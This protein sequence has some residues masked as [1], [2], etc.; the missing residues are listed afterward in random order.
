ILA[1]INTTFTGEATSRWITAMK[2]DAFDE[3]EEAV[4]PAGEGSKLNLSMAAVIDRLFD[5][6]KRYSFEFNRTQESREFEISCERPASMR[7][8]AE[9]HD[10]GKPIK[11]CLGHLASR[12][13]AL[14]I[15]GEESRILAYITP[16]E[17]LV[18]F[19]PGLSDFP[20][21]LEMRTMKDPAKT[22]RDQVWAIK[23][24]ILSVDSLPVLARRLFTQLVKVSKGEA[25]NTELF[26][27]SP[28][29]E[30]LALAQ[31]AVAPVDRTFEVEGK[32]L[33]GQKKPLAE[34]T[35]IVTPEPPPMENEITADA[36]DEPANKAD[37]EVPVQTAPA[38]AER[39]PL[40]AL[41]SPA[42]MPSLAASS[43]YPQVA[44]AIANG[45][46]KALNSPPNPL[47]EPP[48]AVPQQ[49][50]PVQPPPIP[51]SLPI[52]A[53]APTLVAE[54]SQLSEDEAIAALIFP[55]PP[56]PAG[57]PPPEPAPPPVPTPVPVPVAVSLPP[58][59][60]A[61]A[62][63]PPE[64]P[65]P[66]PEAPPAPAAAAE[67]APEPMPAPAPVPARAHLR[68]YPNQPVFQPRTQ[69]AEAPAP[70]AAPVPSPA[71]VSSPAPAEPE[72]PKPASES[73]NHSLEITGQHSGGKDKVSDTN[74]K[75]SLEKEAAD[76]R[77]NIAGSLKGLFESV[78]GA[79]SGLTAVGLEAMHSDDIETVSAV[80]K[81]T[82][83][84]KALRESVVALSKDWQKAIET[85]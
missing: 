18:G 68:E 59:V 33:L 56:R 74:G 80:M 31:N 32:G 82:K 47:H 78:D 49:S 60:T 6:F 15:Q 79:I 53:P 39:P 69:E 43:H 46:P 20:P 3:V 37:E 24:Q 63:P 55:E 41:L 8:N 14:V 45:E 22:S 75:P 16:I 12:S 67:P 9:Y 28:Q 48:Q 38:V 72:P 50:T 17:F 65:K 25:E 35:F 44:A 27:L 71:P 54:P 73:T 1:S 81:Q 11:Y 42:P 23:G 29:E 21:H 57:S 2:D 30:K 51:A 52:S 19:K 61:A 77:R 66:A 40:N 36:E 85:K 84:L 34:R 5:N 64:A 4:I 83:A 26:A 58:F 76:A 13:W 62:A 10:L 7:T 70:A